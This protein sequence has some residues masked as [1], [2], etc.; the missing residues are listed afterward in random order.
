M[1]S[2]SISRLFLGIDLFIYTIGLLCLYGASWFLT[3]EIIIG[4]A[5]CGAFGGFLCLASIFASILMMRDLRRDYIKEKLAES[6][7]AMGCQGC[8]SLTAGRIH[9]EIPFCEKCLEQ[10]FQTTSELLEEGEKRIGLASQLGLT[11]QAEG[12]RNWVLTNLPKPFKWMLDQ[13][14]LHQLKKHFPQAQPFDDSG[15][16]E[17]PLDSNSL[18]VN[19]PSEGLLW[20]KGECQRILPETNQLK[21]G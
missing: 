7:L 17:Y 18:E 10:S 20:L 13:A 4:A 1:L 9:P 12:A 2:D 5:A 15:F 19:I 6:L 11:G 16:V 14:V 8:Q 3:K 21:G